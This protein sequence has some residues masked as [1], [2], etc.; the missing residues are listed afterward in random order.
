[1]ITTYS[2]L[3]TAIAQWLHRTDL[4][5]VIPD[6]IE[7][8]E[9]KL[10][11]YLR[12]KDNELALSPTAIVNNRVTIPATAVAI[13]S[14]W[15]DGYEGSP[16]TAQTL[17]TVIANGTQGLA[18][19]YAWQGTE[20]VFDG[21]GTVEGVLYQEIPALTISNTSNWVLASAPSLYLFGALFEANLYV[22]SMDEAMMWKSRFDQVLAEVN[23]ASA[24]GLYSGPLV[25]RAR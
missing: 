6:F 16:L 9:E 25:A 1:M 24:Q 19:M 12:T 7:L 13:K 11:R 5:S 17:E 23:S 20:L 3:Q 21:T 2:E 18:A 14:L 4:T 15:L 10:N 8:T 22:K